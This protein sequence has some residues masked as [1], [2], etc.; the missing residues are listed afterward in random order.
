MPSAVSRLAA[1]FLLTLSAAFA[2]LR[3]AQVFVMIGPPGSGKSVQAKVLSKKYRIPAISMESLVKAEIGKK[4]PR[5]KALASAV[6]SGELVSD[7]SANQV[8]TSRLLRSDAGRGFILDGYPASEKQAQALD[9]FLTENGFPKPIVIVL[10]AP[11]AV[12][13]ERMKR[14]GRADDAPANIERRIREYREQE[15]FIQRRYGSDVRVDGSGAVRLVS[16]AIERQIEAARAK[17]G[18]KER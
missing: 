18:L 5:A 1:G 8:M 13:R 2:Q 4:T 9:A 12:L 17:R 11:D 10:E 7:D 15:A 16:A 6:A 3:P 14:R